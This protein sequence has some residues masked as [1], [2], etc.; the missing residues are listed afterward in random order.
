MSRRAQHP[1]PRSIRPQWLPAGLLQGIAW[2]LVRSILPAAAAFW[3]GW[4]LL[5]TERTHLSDLPSAFAGL[6]L[7]VLASI[8]LAPL[9]AR[10][11]AHPAGSLYYPGTRS[12]TPPPMY[13]Q[14]EARRKDGR[15]DEAMDLLQSI[16]DQYPREL[17]PYL[18]MIEIAFLELRNPELANAV[19]RRSRQLF[20]RRRER[21]VIEKTFTIQRDRLAWWVERD[22][23]RTARPASK[24]LTLRAKETAE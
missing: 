10:V 8:L 18:D 6:G 23:K 2:W 19:Y 22:M 16:A 13:S 7:V 4:R 12:W 1:R 17:R 5:M 15:L 11:I 9:L 21:K 14:V 24:P 20:T 3:F